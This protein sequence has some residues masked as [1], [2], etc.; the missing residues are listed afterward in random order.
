[1]F[2]IQC[3]IKK[4]AQKDKKVNIQYSKYIFF[5]NIPKCGY[6]W[7]ESFFKMFCIF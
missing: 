5:K 4:K 6:L 1:M 2:I 7:I 3:R